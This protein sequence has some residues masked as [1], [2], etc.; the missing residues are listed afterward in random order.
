MSKSASSVGLQALSLGLVYDRTALE[1]QPL[2]SAFMV[3]DRIA[4]T[5]R[6]TLENILRVCRPVGYPRE[7]KDGEI[8][9][10]HAAHGVEHHRRLLNLRPGQ[11]GGRPGDRESTVR[12]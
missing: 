7:R 10:G 6:R 2:C 4:G 12:W 1:P 8:G 11:R 9:V 3:A 5:E